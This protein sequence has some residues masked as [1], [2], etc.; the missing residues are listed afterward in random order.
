MSHSL[1]ILEIIR[2]KLQIFRDKIKNYQDKIDHD[3]QEEKHIETNIREL[4]IK[5]KSIKENIV[6]S[7]QIFQN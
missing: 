2:T 3:T 4:I 1:N 5:H 6:K 7:T